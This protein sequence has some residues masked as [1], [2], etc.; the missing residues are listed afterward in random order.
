MTDKHRS[1]Q[2][3]RAIPS[4]TIHGSRS[5]RVSRTKAG[6]VGFRR[7]CSQF[8]TVLSGTPIA[9]AK[10]RCVVPIPREAR[11]IRRTLISAR[12]GEGTI[13]AAGRLLIAPVA[14]FSVMGVRGRDSIMAASGEIISFDIS[15]L[16]GER[17]A[18]KA[19]SQNSPCISRGSAALI[20]AINCSATSCHRENHMQQKKLFSL[21][22]RAGDFYHTPD[23]WK[24]K[25]WL[26]PSILEPA[27]HGVEIRYSI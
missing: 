6:P 8:E 25:A 15:G 26:R 10:V 5:I 7:P 2:S 20:D 27:T 3:A 13:G 11:R 24:N 19:K 21:Q 17:W 1:T 18:L 14:L 4:K 16:T 9:A 12:E 23:Q 22:L